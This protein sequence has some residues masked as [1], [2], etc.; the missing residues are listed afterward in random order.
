MFSIL[1][2]I[3]LACLCIFGTAILVL[4]TW[5][6]GAALVKSIAKEIK[7]SGRHG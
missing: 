4:A 7:R 5:I 3:F 2:S 6:V 1:Y